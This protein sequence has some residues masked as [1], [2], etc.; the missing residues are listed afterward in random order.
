MSKKNECMHY[1]KCLEN[2]TISIPPQFRPGCTEESDLDDIDTS[3]HTDRHCHEAEK[4]TL[5]PFVWQMVARVEEL[6]D[7]GDYIVYDIVD[8]SFIVVKTEDNEIKA[9]YNSCLHRG[10]SLVENNGCVTEFKCPYHGFSWRLNGKL[11]SIP[12]AWDFKQFAARP[13]SETCLPEVLVDSWGGFIFIN[14][15]LNAIPLKAYL[16]VLPEHFNRWPIEKS[17]KVLHVSKKIPANWKTTQEAFMESL[18]ARGIHQQMLPYIGDE[19]T[20]YDTYGENISRA[21]TVIGVSSPALAEKL[22][23]EKIAESYLGNNL[24]KKTEGLLRSTTDA[25]K[26]LITIKRERIS[27]KLNIDM[28]DFLDSEI[29]DEYMYCV[30]PNFSPWKGLDST[31]IYR[32]RPNGDD[33]RSCIMDVIFLSC[34]TSD[35]KYERPKT[36]CLGLDEPFSNAK[37]L[38][39]LATVLDQDVDN[40]VYVDKGL[41]AAKKKRMLLSGYQEKIIKNFHST[42]DKYLKVSE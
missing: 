11:K 7:P 3:R 21:M 18:H 33:H 13:K 35:D 34:S 22:S 6:D 12:S 41:R 28:S 9:F 19:Y 40:L 23:E 4:R 14:M 2:E 1:Q 38:G 29:I 42:L 31:M 16:G 27:K 32:F 36:T 20:Q 39:G 26:T 5:W 25:R 10:R 17:K 30:F 24:D 15:D 37:E 8:Q